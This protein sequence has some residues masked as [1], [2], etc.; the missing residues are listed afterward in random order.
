MSGWWPGSRRASQ[1]VS[2]SQVSGSLYQFQFNSDA[3][4]SI[5]I[6]SEDAVNQDSPGVASISPPVDHLG[7][8]FHGRAGLVDDLIE[9]VAN[10]GQAGKVHVLC[11]LGGCGKSM[12]AMTLAQEVAD[13]GF[14][15][16][17]VSANTEASL[18]AGMRQLAISLGAPLDRV[19]NAWRGR[20]SATDLVWSLLSAR[21]EKWVL[22]IDNAD[23]PAILSASSLAVAD[24][25]GWVRPAVGENGSIVLTTRNQNPH[26]WAPWCSMIPVGM[27]SPQDGAS[28]LVEYAGDRPGPRSEAELLARR[29]GGLPL[30]LRLAGVY[31]AAIA[32]TPWPGVINT[33]REYLSVFEH[34]QPELVY[35]ELADPA[36]ITEQVARQMIGRTWDLSIR[37]LE[38]RGFQEARPLLQLLSHLAEAPIPVELL[39]VRGF[40]GIDRLNSMTEARLREVASVLGDLGLVEIRSTQPS[41]FQLMRTELVLH[42]LVRDVS[43]AATTLV[44]RRENY[45]AAL[46]IM[47]NAAVVRLPGSGHPRIWSIWQ[48]Y[49]VHAF[50]LLDESGA[51]CSAN[52][53][54]AEATSHGAFLCA[55]Y[56]VECAEYVEAER[57]YRQILSLNSE[58][59]SGLQH[60]IFMVR[61]RLAI[62]FKYL[63][64]IAEAESE[65]SD[66]VSESSAVFGEDSLE[67]LSVRFDYAGVA[68]EQRM[69]PRAEREYKHVLSALDRQRRPS[70]DKRAIR[71]NLAQILVEQGKIVEGDN[72]LA[73]AIVEVGGD[74][75]SDIALLLMR[76]ARARI[77]A[78]RGDYLSAVVEMRKILEECVRVFGSEHPRAINVM[79]ELGV[80][81]HDSGSLGQAAEILRETL[82]M[83]VRRM[84]AEHPDTLSSRHQLALVLQDLGFLHDARIHYGLTLK[85]R[86]TVLGSNN[87]STLATRFQVAGLLLLEGRESEARREFEVVLD[88]EV[89]ALGRDHPSTLRTRAV[90]AAYALRDGKVDLA[91]S[92]FE[93]IYRARR[94]ALGEDHPETQTSLDEL[95]QVRLA[96][97]LM[98][99]R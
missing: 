56:L 30:A 33:Y 98:R 85:G 51:L 19:R 74:P 92:E 14:T 35:P 63:G 53:R 5:E 31:L 39:D 36:E 27:L 17:W 91:I 21:N 77:L 84:G 10:G 62:V 9:S 54:A 29:L 4:V 41:T 78:A 76:F 87:E 44:T 88:A 42:P 80:S 94:D 2:Q 16:W 95:K 47:T 40:D 28:V 57:R 13:L 71:N 7:R 15:V 38:S 20:E 37:F 93:D 50:Q 60:P 3:E 18:H 97:T 8:P 96:A 55:G 58:L 23:D 32:R 24:G 69:L 89:R 72:L 81:L 45:L 86:E 6:E 64:R 70:I 79:H 65:T 11:G 73:E 52:R 75:D 66:L 68:W 1:R 12:L 26:N 90:I 61:Q 59:F 48:S 46:A 49:A 22:I 82:S 43:R 34:G 83:R 99:R 67:A 25:T